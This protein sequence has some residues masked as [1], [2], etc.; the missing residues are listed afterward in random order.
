MAKFHERASHSRTKADGRSIDAGPFRII[1]KIRNSP[2][3]SKIELVE[4]GSIPRTE[5]KSRKVM[6]L[7]ASVPG[8]K[9]PMAENVRERQ[10]PSLY[11]VYLPSVTLSK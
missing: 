2:V 9:K 5:V 3:R 11:V 4:T 1:H 8:K 6:D 7:R 10:H